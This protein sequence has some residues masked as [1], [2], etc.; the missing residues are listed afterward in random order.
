MTPSMPARDK[1]V[2]LTHVPTTNPNSQLSLRLDTKRDFDL[3]AANL[4]NY[5]GYPR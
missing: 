2:V 1:Y 4:F 5:P 3:P